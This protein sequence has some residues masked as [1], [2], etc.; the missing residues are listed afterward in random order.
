M[1]DD[2]KRKITDKKNNFKMNAEDKI[3][4]TDATLE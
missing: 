3:Y 1:F 2:R 4:V